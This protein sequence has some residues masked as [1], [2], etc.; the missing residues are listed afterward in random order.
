[1]NVAYQRRSVAHWSLGIDAP[2]SSI[3]QASGSY[4]RQR[5]ILVA[6]FSKKYYCFAPFCMV[7]KIM[8][9]CYCDT[10]ILCVSYIAS[11]VHL[12]NKTKSFVEKRMCLIVQNYQEAIR[13]VLGGQF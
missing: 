6:L 7:S 2:P 3:Y 9:L 13:Q 8:L 12:Q 5:N 4:G 11:Y 1:M 10:I